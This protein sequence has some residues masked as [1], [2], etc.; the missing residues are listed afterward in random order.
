[1]KAVEQVLE[2]IC[3]KLNLHAQFPVI[4]LK[5]A[6]QVKHYLE[7]HSLPF[8]VLVDDGETVK[9]VYENIPARK[10]EYE[11]LLKTAVARVGKINVNCKCEKTKSTFSFSFLFA[12]MYFAYVTILSLHENKFFLSFQPF[13]LLL[14]IIPLFLRR[15]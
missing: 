4:T 6:N 14:L 9:D 13:S 8:C 7:K 2:S 12:F 1:M 10:V 11:D 15:K 3:P 5:T